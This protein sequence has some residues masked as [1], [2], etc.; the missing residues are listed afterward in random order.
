VFGQTFAP[1]DLATV[2]MLVV[3]E[4]L[5]S[6]DNALVLGVMAQRVDP[7]RRIKALAYGLVG[8]FVLRVAMISLAAYLLKWSILKLAGGL[9]LLWVAGRHFIRGWQGHRESNRPLTQT[10]MPFWSAVAA[11]ELTDVAFAVDSILAAVALV[12][13]G[14]IGVIHPKLWV[15]ILGGMLGVALM[16]FAAALFARILERFPGFQRSAY[17][18]VLLIGFKLLADWACNSQ[19]DPHRIDFQNPRGAAMWVF[20]GGMLI[21]LCLGLPGPDRRKINER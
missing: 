2:A 1:A 9:Y 19:A 11:I 7:T 17:L 13:P 20:W 16:R 4:G 6:I 3:L 18:L 10:P 14:P 8:A 21:C 12:G 15:I 5:L